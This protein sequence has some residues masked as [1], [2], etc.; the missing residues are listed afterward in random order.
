MEKFERF[1]SDLKG[2]KFLENL[3]ESKKF[4]KLRE[5][6]KIYR[7]EVEAVQFFVFNF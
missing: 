4:E 3:K 1:W 5:C 7:K 6:E 2:E